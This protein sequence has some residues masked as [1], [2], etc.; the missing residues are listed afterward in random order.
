M[1]E[2]VTLRE[3]HTEEPGEPAAGSDTRAG[4]E[5]ETQQATKAEGADAHA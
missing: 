2:V 3:T 4:E 5:T 1:L